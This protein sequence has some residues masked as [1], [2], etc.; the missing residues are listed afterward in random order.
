MLESAEVP[1]GA[2]AGQ[3]EVTNRSLGLGSKRR[4]GSRVK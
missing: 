1:L 2:F 3:V 4:P